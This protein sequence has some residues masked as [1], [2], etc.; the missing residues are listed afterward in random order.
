MA[1]IAS[2]VV[3]LLLAGLCWWLCSHL[4]LPDPGQRLLHLVFMLIVLFLLAAGSGLLPGLQ[5]PLI[6]G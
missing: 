1:V 6:G 5:L 3:Y 2:L 4:P